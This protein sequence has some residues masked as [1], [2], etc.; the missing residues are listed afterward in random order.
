MYRERER[1]L[2]RPNSNRIFGRGMDG[3]EGGRE[4]C[5]GGEGEEEDGEEGQSEAGEE[6]GEK[7]LR[8]HGVVKRCEEE[9]KIIREGVVV[10]KLWFYYLY[11]S[12]PLRA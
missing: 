12:W 5:V 9:R 10:Y 11:I 4:R 1:E 2:Y 8:I 7:R 3:E 6:E